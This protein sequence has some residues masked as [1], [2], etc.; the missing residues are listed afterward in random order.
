MGGAFKT[1]Q[2]FAE[3]CEVE[4]FYSAA[5]GQYVLSEEVPITHF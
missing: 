3:L 2:Q 5:S 4:I 1:N